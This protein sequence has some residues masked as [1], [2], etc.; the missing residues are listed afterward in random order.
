MHRETKRTA[1]P[2][3]V[4]DA[5]YRRDGERCILCASPAG[6]PNAHVVRR[7]QGGMGIEKNIVTLCP[8]CHRA[9][10][11]GKELGRLGQ[12]TTRESLYVQIVAYL[13]GFYPEWNREDT[14][15]RKGGN[16]GK[17]VG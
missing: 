3:S 2:Q 1:I 10:D 15:Y 11:E 6:I 7:S 17:T 9:Y 12:G 5:V 16:Y 8:A 14:I 4:K 13:K